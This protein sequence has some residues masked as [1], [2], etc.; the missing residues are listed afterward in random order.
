MDRPNISRR[1]LIKGVSVALGG[2]SLVGLPGLLPA[3][4][5]EEQLQRL[6]IGTVEARGPNTLRVRTR[7]GLVTVRCVAEATYGRG[8]SPSASLG[9]FVHGDEIVAEGSWMNGVFTA[10]SVVSM[11]RE[12]KARISTRDGNLLHTSAGI[13]ELTPDTTA[14][15]T[16]A[17]IA[18]PLAELRAGDFIGALV[19]IEPKTGHQVA[20][21]V[22]AAA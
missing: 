14:E 9:S 8:V 20:L 6:A 10:T 11:Y 12:V 21:K 16:D 17:F 3:N 1:Q 5:T 18:R 2:F 22:G 19:W 13:V 15:G 7:N 4:A